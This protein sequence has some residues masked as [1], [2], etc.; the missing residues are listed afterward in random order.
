MLATKPPRKYN[1][2]IMDDNGIAPTE[3]EIEK[4]HKENN[5]IG[6]AHV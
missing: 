4:F 2:D 1:L 6:R 5:E 3:E